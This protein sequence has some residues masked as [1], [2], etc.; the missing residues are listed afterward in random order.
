MAQEDEPDEPPDDEG[1]DRVERE[2]VERGLALDDALVPAGLAWVPELE[3]EL[4]A[5]VDR[6]REV[7][8]GAGLATSASSAATRRLR[9]SISDRRPLTSS[10]TRSSSIVARMRPAA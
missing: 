3:R 9:A 6:E 8:R 7:L 10:S 4:A 5:R 1:L 2:R